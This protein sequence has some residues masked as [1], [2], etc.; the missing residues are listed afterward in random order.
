M[1][2]PKIKFDEKKIAQVEALASRLNRDQIADYF[3]IGRSTYYLVEERQPEVREAYDKGKAKA[4]KDV[5]GS[6]LEQAL[7]GNMTA[8]IFYLKT[9]A[10]WSEKTQVDVTTNGGSIT[11]SAFQLIG[12]DSTNTTSE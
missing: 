2:R 1:G 10:N 4:V 7:N 5:A 9:Q 8:A 12:V 6:L 11:P 3:G